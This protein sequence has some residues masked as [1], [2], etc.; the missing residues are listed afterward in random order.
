M[1]HALAHPFVWW[2]LWT[3]TTNPGGV[4]AYQPRG[5][6]FVSGWGSDISELTLAFAIVAV[7]RHRNCHVKGCWR[8]GHA[9]PEHGHPSC[10]RHHSRASKLGVTALR[11]K[12]G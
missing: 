4:H 5:Y 3:T 12:G 1:W 8:L 6:N 11:S 7:L 2:W 10:R 9:D